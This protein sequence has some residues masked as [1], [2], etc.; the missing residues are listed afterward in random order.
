MRFLDIAN[1]SSLTKENRLL[2]LQKSIVAMHRCGIAIE[3]IA[4]NLELTTQDVESVL[5][6]V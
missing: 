5:N 6:R 2:G 3:E 1:T 4:K